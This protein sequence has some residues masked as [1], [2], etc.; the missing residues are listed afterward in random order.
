MMFSNRPNCIFRYSGGD[1]D[2]ETAVRSDSESL[3]RLV[4]RIV[5]EYILYLYKPL[6]S[7]SFK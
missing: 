3:T 1:S 4:K 6:F 7:H 5:I 2:N